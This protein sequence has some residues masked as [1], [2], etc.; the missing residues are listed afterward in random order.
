MT[1]GTASVSQGARLCVDS[2]AILA[3]WGQW[4]P[5]LSRRKGQRTALMS[6]SPAQHR[7]CCP[8]AVTLDQLLASNAE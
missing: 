7:M 8:Q 3:H 1:A 6:G 5:T 2:I 4:R